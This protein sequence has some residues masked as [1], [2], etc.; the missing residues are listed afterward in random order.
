VLRIFHLAFA[1][2]DNN[3]DSLFGTG[4]VSDNDRA[5]CIMDVRLVAYTRSVLERRG[6]GVEEFIG[7]T[8]E[9]NQA[10]LGRRPTLS[11]RL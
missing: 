9:I 7:L 4:E 6:V 11:E 3:L 1:L 5:A 8:V 10:C 2:L